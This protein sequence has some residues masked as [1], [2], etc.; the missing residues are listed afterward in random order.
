MARGKP[1]SQLSSDLRS[2]LALGMELA[3]R[4]ITLEL[5]RRGPYWT[6]QFE[7]AWEVAA[8]QVRIDS[9]LGDQATWEQIK[10]GPLSRQVTPVFVPPADESLRGYTIGNLMEY[11]DI[12]MDLEPGFDGRYRWERPRATAVGD[13]KKDDDGNLTGGRDWFARYILGGD[14]TQTLAFSVK[15]GMRLAGFTR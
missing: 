14:G 5:K 9:N 12:A 15:Q 7:A 6:G 2:G 1:L 10:N 13:G 11:A 4:D 3:A 8:G